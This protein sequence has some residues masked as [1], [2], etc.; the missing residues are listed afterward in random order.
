MKTNVVEGVHEDGASVQTDGYGRRQ[1][2]FFSVAFSFSQS[3]ME[4]VRSND[5]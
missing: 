1:N 3:A 2:P 4:L 5:S